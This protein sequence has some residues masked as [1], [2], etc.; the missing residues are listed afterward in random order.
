MRME[1][2]DRR[3]RALRNWVRWLPVVAIP[4]SVL[5]A[6]AWLHTQ[7]WKRDFEFGRLSAQES[8][9]RAALAAY[10]AEGAGLQDLDRLEYM[11]LKLDLGLREPE[12]EQIV[13][14]EAVMAPLGSEA[15][16]VASTR[17]V[18][19]GMEPSAVTAPAPEAVTP[20]VLEEVPVSTPV[21][22]MGLVTLETAEDDLSSLLGEL[23]PVMPN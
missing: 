19:S 18:G 4:L 17:P 14:I 1:A 10:D 6:D 3:R 12:P 11:A 9:L 13:S 21:R 8:R 2:R 15:F 20:L 7:N 16:A 22:G 23:A 5:F